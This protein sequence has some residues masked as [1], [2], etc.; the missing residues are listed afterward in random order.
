MDP[1]IPAL[2]QPEP[3]PA[4]RRA[5]SL[6]SALSRPAVAIAVISLLL[7]GWQ[8]LE[9]RERLSDLQQE[10]AKR[11]AEQGAEAAAGRTLAKQN[12]EILQSLTAKFGALDA[13]LAEAQSQQL[14]LE[15]MYQELSKTRDERLLAEIEQALAIAAQQLQL[16]GNVEAAL[17]ALQ[18]A[19]AR[20]A[21][22]GQAQFLPLRKLIN[23]DIERLKALPLADV[24]G[25]ALKLE[26]VIAAIDGL[27]LAF[28][29]RARA[30]GE[31]PAKAAKPV[32]YW[33]GLWRELWSE[34]KLLIRI[35]RIDQAEPALL[36]PSQVFFLRENLKLRLI[37]AR[38]SLLQRDGRSF[39]EDLHQARD[40][41]DRYFD[42]RTK[43][44]QMA[45]ATL[46][47]LAAADLAVELP[48]LNESL[49]SLR[50]FKLARE[51]D[52]PVTAPR[53]NASGGPAKGRSGG[54]SA[55]KGSASGGAGR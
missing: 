50:T 44:V 24:P 14:A 22:A 26:G 41:L 51:R 37:D 25:I 33:D 53:P 10:L 12:Q 8:W 36:S 16:A 34:M 42:R 35:E 21:R 4:W 3:R 38:L 39:R 28:E 52:T 47:S 54:G 2:T 43:P 13:K 49:A 27:P 32:G 1:E 5:F 20:L 45:V 40:W 17:I 11:L 30:V 55:E 31:V 15:A 7:L 46:N 6:L 19:D 48:T 23:R 29:Q 9:T 18:S